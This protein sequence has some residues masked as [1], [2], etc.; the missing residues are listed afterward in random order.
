[1]KH[2][3]FLLVTACGITFLSACNNQSGN[4]DSVDSAKEMNNDALDSNSSRI[5]ST[6]LEKN[7]ADFV[8]EV[9]N[10]GMKEI[11]LGKMA[12]DKSSNQRVKDF[13][14]M[15]I[16]DHTKAGEK[17]QEIAAAKNIVLPATLGDDAKKDSADLS[18]KSGADFD[19]AYIKMMVDDH[20]KVVKSFEKEIND[21]KDPDLKNFTTTTIETIRMHLDSAK[22]IKSGM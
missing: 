2:L 5:S 18:K 16:T 11:A 7:D 12:Q 21:C 13:G 19:K 17:L 10:G 4:Q 15:M 20:E 8:V 14:A 3:F 6:P 22:A 9:T 1:M